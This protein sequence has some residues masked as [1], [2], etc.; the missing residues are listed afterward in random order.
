MGLSQGMF[1]GYSLDMVPCTFQ[2]NSQKIKQE[3][4]KS[5]MLRSYD[6]T[7]FLGIVMGNSVRNLHMLGSECT[8]LPRLVLLCSSDWL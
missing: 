7:H 5:A 1:G 6:Q 3:Y 8:E 2:E 4:D